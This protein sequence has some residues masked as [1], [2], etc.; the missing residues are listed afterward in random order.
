MSTG[1]IGSTMYIIAIIGFIA[2]MAWLFSEQIERQRNP[3]QNLATRAA[4]NGATQ[5]TLQRNR[6]GHYIASGRI[7][8]VEAEFI[9]DTGATDVAVSSSVASRAGLQAGQ[10]LTVTTANG[11]TTAYATM[12]E[13]LQL[14]NITEHNVRA[15]IVP[16]LGDIEV[17]L[18]MSFLKR[19]DFAQRGDTLILTSRREPASE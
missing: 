18:G 5:V 7:N 19:L 1:R 13:V 4:P 2:L 10:P 9:L 15:T 8:T 3:N 6:R 11:L 16:N 17:L 14:G 12:I